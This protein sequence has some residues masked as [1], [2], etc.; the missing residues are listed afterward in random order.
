MPKD[1]NHEV[2][3]DALVHQLLQ[4]S[5]AQKRSTNTK[6]R[7]FECE[8]S[9]ACDMCLPPHCC[10]VLPAHSLACQRELPA[11]GPGIGQSHE[12]SSDDSS[13][14]LCI[15]INDNAE[16]M[17]TRAPVLRPTLPGRTSTLAACQGA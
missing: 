15:V 13:V 9:T 12:Y 2:Q 1:R 3:L 16:S 7:L 4:P 10:G 5:K 11:W 8:E 6:K 17:N 14:H